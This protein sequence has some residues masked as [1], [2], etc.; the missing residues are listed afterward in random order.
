[1][2]TEQVP[3]DPFLPLVKL[4][5]RWMIKSNPEA[6]FGEYMCVYVCTCEYIIFVVNILEQW[7][8]K[9]LRLYMGESI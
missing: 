4:L 5:A 2:A 7:F 3:S 1:M 8:V 9:Y 6:D